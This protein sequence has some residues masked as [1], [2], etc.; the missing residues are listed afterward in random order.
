MKQPIENLMPILSTRVRALKMLMNHFGPG[1]WPAVLRMMSAGRFEGALGDELQD[2]LNDAVA[3]EA[4]AVWDARIDQGHDLYPVDVVEFC[5]LFRVQALEYDPIGYFASKE[6]AI[7]YVRSVWGEWLV[8]EKRPSVDDLF[9]R[10]AL[11]PTPMAPDIE[12][13]EP[14]V[15]SSIFED[16]EFYLDRFEL[17]VRGWTRSLQQRFLPN[18]DRWKTV[19]HWQ[20]YMGKATYFVERVMQAEALAEFRALFDASLRRRGLTDA[21]REAF[22]AERDR[23]RRPYRVWLAKQTPED[24]QTQIAADEFAQAF[25]SARARGYRTPHK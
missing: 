8:E 13:S 24:I 10:M 14:Q 12:E 22:M 17:Q 21:D 18:P 3:N 23:L 6:D 9:R 11:L 15:A 25:E 20:N 4:V 7:D 5:G 2:F 1:N 16:D 19:N